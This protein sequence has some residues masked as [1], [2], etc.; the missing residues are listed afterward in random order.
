MRSAPA[1]EVAYGVAPDATG[2]PTR[3]LTS[4]ESDKLVTDKHGA[5]GP[6]RHLTRP[7]LSAAHLGHESFN[8]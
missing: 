3:H 6:G 7:P 8:L 5:M 4:S 2:P 1:H